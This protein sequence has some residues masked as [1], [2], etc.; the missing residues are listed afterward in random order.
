MTHFSIYSFQSGFMTLINFAYRTNKKKR[1][2][3][4]RSSRNADNSNII[5]QLVPKQLQYQ[6]QMICST[7]GGAVL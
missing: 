6:D 1:K 4:N 7:D 5:I 3:I 2:T